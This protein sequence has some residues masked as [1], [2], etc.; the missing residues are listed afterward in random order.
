MPEAPEV[1]YLKEMLKTKIKNHDIINII[2]N[3]DSEVN[4]PKQSRVIDCDSK[5]KLLW[6][7]TN[8][9]YIHIHMMISGWF[10]FEKPKVCKYEFIFD[11]MSI[12]VDDVRRFSKVYIVNSEKEHKKIIDE[13]GLDFFNNEITEENFV[14]IIS[15]S[16]KNI[17]SLLLE[18][19]VF[20]GIGN[21]IRN[22]ALYLSKI[23]PIAKSKNIDSDS[24]KV[25]YE[26]IKFVMF[27]SLYELLEAD[28]IKISKNIKKIS[29]SNLEIPY[30]Y[31]VYD[32]EKDKLGNKITKEKIAGRW[33]YYVKSIQ[34]E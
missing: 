16:T 33:T 21:Y 25:L 30:K 23:H 34:K 3:T 19:T 4:L 17:S 20:C 9:F 13:L 8:D 1:F 7:K 14:D 22:E 26:K 29:P 28:N 31:K 12:Y 24:I 11:N 6:I 15:N 10:V 2:S 32:R 18:Q 27:S 5:G